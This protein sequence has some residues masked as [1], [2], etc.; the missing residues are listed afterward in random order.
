MM[1]TG[2]LLYIFVHVP[3]LSRTMHSTEQ[4]E[5][6]FWFYCCDGGQGRYHPCLAEAIKDN[7]FYLIKKPEG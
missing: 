5:I 4:L 1:F 6:L 2:K 7:I 3:V